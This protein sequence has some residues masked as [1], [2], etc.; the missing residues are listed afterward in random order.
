MRNIVIVDCD[1]TGRN[2]IDDIVRK[3][4]NPVVLESKVL[5]DIWGFDGENKS[6]KEDYGL[7]DD[8]DI[9][10]YGNSKHGKNVIIDADE[11]WMLVEITSIKGTKEKL[12]RI[13]SVISIKE[14]DNK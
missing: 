5:S 9:I 1:S 12:L 11:D 4:Y 13:S 3:N 7:D 14:V 6:S 2:F 10:N 8:F